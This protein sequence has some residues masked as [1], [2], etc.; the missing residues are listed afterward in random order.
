M[1]FR[2]EKNGVPPDQLIIMENELWEK[3]RQLDISTVL[4]ERQTTLL[5]KHM[6]P[7]PAVQGHNP[8]DV[9]DANLRKDQD[10]R[11]ALQSFAE[12]DKG[13]KRQAVLCITVV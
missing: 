4:K 6:T 2:A 9:M 8:E 5:T 12:E 7:I 3:R 11:A 10:G 13:L 1:Y